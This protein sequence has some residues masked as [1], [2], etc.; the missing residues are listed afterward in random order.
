MFRRATTLSCSKCDYTCSSQQSLSF[1]MLKHDEE[2]LPCNVCSKKFLHRSNLSNH[3]LQ[4]SKKEL[5]TSPP[6]GLGNLKSNVSTHHSTVKSLKD[7]SHNDLEEYKTS[8]KYISWSKFGIDNGSQQLPTT[9][10]HMKGKSINVYNTSGNS[11][12]KCTKSDLN[13]SHK[14]TLT[15]HMK[16]QSG[17]KQYACDVCDYKC[18][19]EGRLIIHKRTHNKDGL[20]SCVVCDYKCLRKSDLTQHV[21]RHLRDKNDDENSN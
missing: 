19:R 10:G 2:N 7:V 9:N 13:F 18:S 12:N 5:F 16:S 1:H 20:F 11:L 15:D 3:L 8:K 17:E 6:L 21:R 14:S 4:H